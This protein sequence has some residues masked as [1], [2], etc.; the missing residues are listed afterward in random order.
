MA[1]DN[2]REPGTIRAVKLEAYRGGP[3]DPPDTAWVFMD[4]DAGSSQ[5]FGG[6][7]LNSPEVVDGW[8]KHFT[9]A[10]GVKKYED[11]VGKKCY[12]LRSFGGWNEPIH[13]LETLDG[14]RV[15]VNTFRKSVGFEVKETEMQRKVRDIKT[16]IER[17]KRQIAEQEENLATVNEGYKEWD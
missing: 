13:G 4:F 5:G 6:L 1:R 3:D 8:V 15:T 17:M 9:E 16:S 10:F 11:L 2:H 12:A 7:Y 14:K